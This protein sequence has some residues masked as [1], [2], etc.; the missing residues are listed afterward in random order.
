MTKL[1]PLW[2]E[3]R[4]I[5]PRPWQS[6]APVSQP[7]VP[8]PGTELL[9]IIHELTDGKIP[10]CQKCTDLA[11]RMNEWGPDGCREHLR[12]IVDDILPRAEKWLTAEA[13]AG[14]WLASLKVNA[15]DFAKRA[16]IRSYVV[17]AIDQY[18]QRPPTQPSK[19]K[20]EEPNLPDLPLS[21]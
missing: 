5:K 18:E 2:M 8:G 15:P 16:G 12:E 6:D 19:K 10:P 21:N 17:R 14:S 9:T 4:N 13:E 7:L 1:I 3:K 11:R 20:S